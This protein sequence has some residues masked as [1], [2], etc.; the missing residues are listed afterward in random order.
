MPTHKNDDYPYAKTL[1]DTITKLGDITTERI[2][3]SNK[4]SQF[5]LAQS[6]QKLENPTLLQIFSFA[7]QANGNYNF[8]L[9]FAYF[10]SLMSN[11]QTPEGQF[12]SLMAFSSLR[13]TLQSVAQH[14]FCNNHEPVY[15]IIKK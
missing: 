14:G 3:K 5:Y 12:H 7:L 2:L 6:I 11:C 10:Q 9:N 4:E 13:I 1:Y 15:K 8:S